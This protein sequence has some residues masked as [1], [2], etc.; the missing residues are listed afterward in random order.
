M[1]PEIWKDIPGYEGS[2]QASNLGQIRSLDRV[3]YREDTKIRLKGRT[4]KLHINDKGSLVVGLHLEGQ[5]ITRLIHRLILETFIGPSPDGMEIRRR[6]K[7]RLDNSLENLC[8]GTRSE[9]IQDRK[10]DGRDGSKVVYCSDGRKF[11]SLTE[12]TRITNI[13]DACISECCHGKQKTAGGFN[14][15][16]ESFQIKN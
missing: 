9:N 13:D 1:S 6:S 16:Y 12:A 4:L 10:R 8:W 5:S 2:Y 11:N 7:G 14:W 3:I 15:S